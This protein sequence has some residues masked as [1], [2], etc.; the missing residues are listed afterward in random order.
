MKVGFVGLGMMGGPI[1]RNLVK[2]G[3]ALVVHDVKAEAME[4][5]GTTNIE[6][7]E[8]PAQVAANAGLLF[9][10]LPGPV[11]VKLVMLERNG[12][13]STGK[14]GLLVVDLTTNSVQ[15]AKEVHEALAAK[16]IHYMDAPVSG[17]VV[18]AEGASLSIMCGASKADFAKALPLLQSIG[19]HC[20]H[21]GAVGTGCVAKLCNNMV[22][23]ANTAATAEGLLLAHKAG[24]DPKTMVDVLEHSSGGSASLGRVA[25]HGLSGDWSAEF[26]L[27]LAWKDLRL[28]LELGLQAGSPLTYGAVTMSL[29]EQARACGWGQDDLGVVARVLEQHHQRKLCDK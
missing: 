18:G 2:A 19:K 1:A 15:C 22:A 28:A 23:F 9:C 29:I 25:K 21:I 10:S 24:V 27:D 26:A 4:R 6:A 3:H 7:V 16:G 13:A 8:S 14:T 17:G 11:E 5:L 12:I 20:T